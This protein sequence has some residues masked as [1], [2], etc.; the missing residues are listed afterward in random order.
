MTKEEFLKLAG[1][2][3]DELQALNKLDNFYDYEKEFRGIWQG[4]GNSVL[5]KNIGDLPNDKRKKKPY[6]SGIRNNKQ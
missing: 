1:S 6:N 3:Y 2:R 5:E 4:L